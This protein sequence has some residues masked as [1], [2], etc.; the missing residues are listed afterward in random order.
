M[1]L[2]ALAIVLIGAAVSGLTQISKRFGWQPRVV[3]AV[4]CVVLSAGY[5]A[6]RD[7]AP[8][9]VFQAVSVYIVGTWGVA[10][11]IYNIY[12]LW[13]AVIAPSER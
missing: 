13:D 6:F 8:S 5:V 12:K 9:T 10:N 2:S 7:F 4:L 11:I 3:V 1:E